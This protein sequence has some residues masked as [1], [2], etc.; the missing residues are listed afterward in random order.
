VA[1]KPSTNG[2]C[3]RFNRTVK[4][5]LV[6]LASED[7]NNWDDY[8]QRALLAYRTTPHS[9]TG[10][11]PQYL[12]Y[13]HEIK[14]PFDLL[15]GHPL[16]QRSVESYAAQLTN[17]I[18][19][20]T[21]I[22]REVTGEYQR[23]MKA[24]YDLGAVPKLFE[25]GDLVKIRRK[26]RGLDESRLF[27]LHWTMPFRVTRVRGV[28]LELVNVRTGQTRV[29]HHDHCSKLNRALEDAGVDP[30][31]EIGWEHPGIETGQESF[32][33]DQ[34]TLENPNPD[35]DRLEPN[36]TTVTTRSGRVSRRLNNA[37]LIYS[38]GVHVPPTIEKFVGRVPLPVDAESVTHFETDSFPYH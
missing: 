14:L 22:A 15:W 8:L 24:H 19:R 31:E 25:V 18:T 36:R 32:E 9:A 16:P 23:R 26:T 5:L 38:G 17:G 21:E 4:E 3:E 6:R 29:E 10:F 1:F 33:L 30:N 35:F 12:L 7:P 37:D 13:G 2:A 28:N 27:Q 20:A 34:I 11:T